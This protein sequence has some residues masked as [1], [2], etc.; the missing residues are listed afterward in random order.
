[1]YDDTP[2]S[3]ILQQGDIFQNVP[4][5]FIPPLPLRIIREKS[6]GVAPVVK[7]AD[8]FHYQTSLD[9]IS[10]KSPN[11]V[12]ET[13]AVDLRVRTAMI[14]SQTCDVLHRK[15]IAICPVFSF[16]EYKEKL[17]SELGCDERQAENKLQA[18]R[19][20]KVNY[21]FYLESHNNFPESLADLQ[22]I[23]TANK[24]F[25]KL[26]HRSV[27][28]NNLSRHILAHQLGNYFMRPAIP[29]KSDG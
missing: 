26:E 15:A 9:L 29:L 5:F 22:E 28:L 4:I 17:I 14:M 3:D 7:I 6:E 13:A 27:S 18:I 1:M 12:E 23:N 16:S 25:L 2:P 21:F 24:D 11:I 8:I 20:R 10:E 19:D